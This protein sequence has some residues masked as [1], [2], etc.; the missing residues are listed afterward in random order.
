MLNTCKKIATL[1][2]LLTAL[3][4]GMSLAGEPVDINTATAEEIALNV[5][6]IGS[7]KAAAIVAYREQN[8]P[9]MHIDELINVKGIG[10]ATV[11]KNRDLLKVADSR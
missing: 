7:S 8:G 10:L 6:G 11:D 5:S 9:F 4:S 1:A 2:V 3:I